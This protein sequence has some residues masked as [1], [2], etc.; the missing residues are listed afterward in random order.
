[1]LAIL[2]WSIALVLMAAS[3]GLLILLA[4]FA[5][6]D[7]TASTT[8]SLFHL[9]AI[10]ANLFM[11]ISGT[12]FITLIARQSN[13]PYIAS[14]NAF[15]TSLMAGSKMIV[16]MGSGYLANMLGWTNFFI[17]VTVISLMVLGVLFMFAPFTYSMRS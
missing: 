5:T 14:Q 4:N 9:Q 13:R 16:A 2:I 11:G 7:F 3:N 12:A 15:L 8:C 17:A 10:S 6:T 1:M